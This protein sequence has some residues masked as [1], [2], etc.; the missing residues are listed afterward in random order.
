MGDCH[1]YYDEIRISVRDPELTECWIFV[2]GVG[3]CPFQFLGWHYKAFPS[4]LTS[5]DVLRLWIE[6]KEDPIL[7]ERKDPPATVPN[8]YPPSLKEIEQAVAFAMTRP[9]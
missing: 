1:T 7:W 6:G 5:L 4:S 3:D 9:K 8:I 2:R